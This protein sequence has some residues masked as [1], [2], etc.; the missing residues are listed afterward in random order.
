ML[1]VSLRQ[2]ETATCSERLSGIDKQAFEGLFDCREGRVSYDPN[3][4][5]PT[6]L[7]STQPHEHCVVRFPNDISLAG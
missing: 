6:H 1:R 4:I 7:E 3:N 5:L 2:A